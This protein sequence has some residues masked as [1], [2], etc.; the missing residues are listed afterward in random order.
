M[1]S[2]SVDLERGGGRLRDVWRHV[3]RRSAE[4]RDLL[5]PHTEGGDAHH[6]LQAESTGSRWS[7][8]VEWPPSDASPAY[9]LRPSLRM[10]V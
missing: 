4:R 6:R 2:L 5:E 7:L 1:A 10:K 3:F 8:E 9:S